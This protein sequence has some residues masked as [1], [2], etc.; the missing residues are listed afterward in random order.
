MSALGFR[1]LIAGD[2]VLLSM[3]PSQH[4]E[5]GIEHRGFSMEEGEALAESGPAWTAYRGSRIVG[6]AGF[7][8]LFPGHASVW[9]ALSDDM[10]A[11][12]LACTRF[13]R[14]EIEHAPYHRI[15]ALVDAGNVRAMRWAE[16]VG[17]EPAHVLQGY[18]AAARPHILFERV[19][20]P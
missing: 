7:R 1:P 2:A 16:L 19:R 3:Q 9:A 5:F 6:I 11:D 20:L 15:D 8:E 18:G 17:L 10:G 13:A 14:W 12:H 4:F